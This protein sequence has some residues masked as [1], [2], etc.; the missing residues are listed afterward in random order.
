MSKQNFTLVPSML[1]RNQK[2]AH[3]A[4]TES[5]PRVYDHV[6]SPRPM[7]QNVITVGDEEMQRARSGEKINLLSFKVGFQQDGTLLSNQH[8]P[9]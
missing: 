3:N 2:P 4:K 7:K 1:T 8:Q 9:T 6:G 5:N